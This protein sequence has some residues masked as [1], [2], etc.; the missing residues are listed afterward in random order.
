MFKRAA[1]SSP[2]PKD[3]DLALLIAALDHSWNSYEARLSRG[4]QVVNY[5]LVAVAILAN[6]YVSA[7]ND[8]LYVVAAVIGLSGVALTTM[9]LAVGG[10]QRRLAKV[11]ELALIDVQDLVAE[12]LQV[13]AL[14][15]Q[16]EV[17]AKF[18]LPSMPF[19]Y[20]AFGIAA[21]LSAGAVAYALI[22]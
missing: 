17:P 6:A 5:Y 21:L 7:F 3:N 20:I 14:R 4:L 16:R 10:R 19:T 22:H 1:L 12:R 18:S 11:S 8:K 9:A 15:I 13:G 2:S